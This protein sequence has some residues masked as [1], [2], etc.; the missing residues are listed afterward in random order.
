MD[1]I[2]SSSTKITCR[3]CGKNIRVGH[4]PLEPVILPDGTYN[5]YCG[6]CAKKITSE[7]RKTTLVKATNGELIDELLG[8]FRAD[9]ETMLTAL[10]ARGYFLVQGDDGK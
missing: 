3:G 10:H 7:K 2:R 5:S 6:K 8:R 4:Y 1:I 9:R